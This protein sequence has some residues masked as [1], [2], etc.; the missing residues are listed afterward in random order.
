MVRIDVHYQG[1]LHT[2]ARHEPSSRELETDAPKDNE[3]RGESFSPTDLLATSLGTC[4]LT[5]M[6]ITARRHDWDMRDARAS[7]EKH[8]LTAPVRRV[9]KLVVRIAMPPGI[10]EAARPVLERAAM[11]CPVHHSLHPEIELD[12]G[13]A[14]SQVAL[15]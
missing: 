4:M 7:V 13:F 12:I 8:M 10:P 9:G 1:D 5:V 11:S 15:R 6:G 14:W 2:T 3:G